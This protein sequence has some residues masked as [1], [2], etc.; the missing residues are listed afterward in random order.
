MLFDAEP[1]QR[2]APLAAGRYRVDLTFHRVSAAP[3]EIAIRD[4]TPAEASALL[5]LKR[6]GVEWTTTL[7]S[8]KEPPQILPTDPLRFLRVLHYLYTTPTPPS[9]VDPSVL[10]V[11]EGFCGPEA[12]LLRF[13]LARLRDDKAAQERAEAT[14]RSQY[15]SSVPALRELKGR[16]GTILRNR[17]SYQRRSGA[18]P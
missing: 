1:L 10:D 8:G 15:P 5:G 12:T 11:L 4:P 7:P 18:R 17:E 9:E 2:H 13:E 14:I 6:L 16:G 3:F